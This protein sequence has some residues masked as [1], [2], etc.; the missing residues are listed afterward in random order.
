MGL[1][2]NGPGMHA[3][4]RLATVDIYNAGGTPGNVALSWG[5]AEINTAVRGISE[6]IRVAS[7]IQELLWENP[8]NCHAWT[9]V[10]AKTCC[11]TTVRGT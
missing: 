11:C 5:E 3:L 6:G 9:K 1:P 4:A 8:N 7:A 2:S 10:V